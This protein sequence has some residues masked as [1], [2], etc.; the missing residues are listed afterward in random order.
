ML[1]FNHNGENTD[2]SR[3]NGFCEK[4][5]QFFGFLRCFHKKFKME[6]KKLTN[7]YVAEKFAFAFGGFTYY[8][9]VLYSIK[10]MFFVPM[11]TKALTRRS[12]SLTVSPSLHI[13]PI[14][15]QAVFARF[16]H[17]VFVGLK[18]GLAHHFSAIV[19][20]NNILVLNIRLDVLLSVTCHV[21]IIH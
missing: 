20:S 1:L 12:D 9:L 3:K 16:S 4:K 13:A 6:I 7:W 10:I 17:F 15:V 21:Y 19:V 2:F 8:F 14:C 11:A 5:G 18:F